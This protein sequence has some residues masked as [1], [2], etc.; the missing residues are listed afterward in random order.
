LDSDESPAIYADTLEDALKLHQ[1]REEEI[2]NHEKHEHQQA[3]AW[4][5]RWIGDAKQEKRS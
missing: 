4:I 2:A 3:L 1:Q 5:S